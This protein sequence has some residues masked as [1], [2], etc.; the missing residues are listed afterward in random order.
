MQRNLGRSTE[1][2]DPRA[3]RPWGQSQSVWVTESS[4]VWLGP[5]PLSVSFASHGKGFGF[6]LKTT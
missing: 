2:R 5:G 1:A 4:P 3:E 6:Y